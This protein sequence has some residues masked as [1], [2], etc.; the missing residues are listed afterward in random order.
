MQKLSNLKFTFGIPQI[1]YSK[2]TLTPSQREKSKSKFNTIDT[3]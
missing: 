3:K 2:M 1:D